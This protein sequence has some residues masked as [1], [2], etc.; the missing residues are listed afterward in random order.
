V[1]LR[2]RLAI[3]VACVIAAGAV[4]GSVGG[5][6]YALFSGQASNA[7]AGLSADADWTPPNVSAAVIAKAAGGDAGYARQG[8]TLYYYANVV[9]GGNPGTGVGTV[10]ADVGLGATSLTSAGG[11]WTVEGVTYNYRS[12]LQTAPGTVPAGTYPFSVSSADLDTPPNSQTQNGFSV[13]VDNTA[14]TAADVQTA[15]GAATV[16]RP[17][18][19]DTVTFTY[20]EPV[21]RVSILPTWTT[22]TA[23]VVVRINNGTPD[24][25]QVY[26]STNTVQLLVTSTAGLNLGRNDYV[27]TNRT[28]GATGTPST[29]VRTGNSIAITLGTQ[30]GAGTT[31][32][33]TGGMTMTW[34]PSATVTDR[35]GNP[36]SA[37]AVNE[38]GAADREF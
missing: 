25:L 5:R 32:G 23:N 8:G 19:G 37:T 4:T 10:T 13:I 1:K 27:S 16:G 30:S 26:N 34:T 24:V 7:S 38:T 36:G 28:F 22:G 21:E 12:A 29:M 11:P 2:R 6:T 33:T 17:E 18:Q 35:A 14:A 20:S 9:D 31:A 3:A 15:N